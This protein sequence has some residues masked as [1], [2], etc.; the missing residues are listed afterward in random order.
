MPPPVKYSSTQKTFTAPGYQPLQATVNWYAQAT[1]TRS[2]MT[3]GSAP[4]GA[5]EPLGWLRGD[6][7]S[8]HNRG[9]LIGNAVGGAG[10]ETKNLV[11]LTAG[12]NHPIMYEFE[13]LVRRYISNQAHADSFAYHVWCRYR[14]YTLTPEFPVPGASGNPFCLFPAP[15]KLYLRLEKPAKT[16]ISLEKLI[17]GAGYE[18]NADE[19]ANVKTAQMDDGYVIVPNGVYK[20]G[21]GSAHH[22]ELQATCWQIHHDVDTSLEAARQYAAHLGYTKV[23]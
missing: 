19:I 1:L 4:D 6:C 22:P 17:E 7:P 5:I 9:H 21:H 23:Q 15:S 2:N 18:A 12:T 3:G 14:G 20:E 13:N 10:N 11:T 8:H 16:R